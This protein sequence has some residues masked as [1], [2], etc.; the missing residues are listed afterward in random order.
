MTNE[1]L[2]E[3]LQALIQLD[4]ATSEIRALQE[5]LFTWH[6]SAQQEGWDEDTF[7]SACGQYEAWCAVLNSVE[8]RLSAL[9]DGLRAEVGPATA[10]AASPNPVGGA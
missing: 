4:A 6:A 1:Q 5:I 3:K 10:P 9:S 2:S 7:Q 8:T